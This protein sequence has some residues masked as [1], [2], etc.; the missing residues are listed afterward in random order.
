MLNI[1]EGPQKKVKNLLELVDSRK[2]TISKER[3][4]KT[5]AVQMRPNIKNYS[6][7]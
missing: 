4:R 5:S 3:D 7:L 1:I 2:N 6:S